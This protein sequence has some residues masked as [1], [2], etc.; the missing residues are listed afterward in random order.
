MTIPPVGAGEYARPELLVKVADLA[1][2][3]AALRP[4]IRDVC[5]RKKYEVEHV[6]GTR[7][8][9]APTFPIA[10]LEVTVSLSSAP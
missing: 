1:R 5:P 9:P 4:V 2:T 10:P 6:S 7:W 3:D 8:V